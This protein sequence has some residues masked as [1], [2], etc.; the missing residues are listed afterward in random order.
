MISVHDL[1]S[2]ELNV[3]LQL[4]LM[5]PRLL[6]CAASH[7]FLFPILYSAMSE[8]ECEQFG[9]S[10][11]EARIGFAFHSPIRASIYLLLFLSYSSFFENWTDPLTCFVLF[12]SRWVPP[13]QFSSLCWFEQ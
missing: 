13:L 2:S 10:L 5:F 7:G 11:F 8:R 9:G 1:L 4:F 3:F 6:L 12:V